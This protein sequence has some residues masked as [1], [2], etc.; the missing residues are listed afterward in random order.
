[1]TEKQRSTSHLN[2]FFRKEYRTMVRYVKARIDDAAERDGED[3]VQDVMASIITAGDVTVPINNLAAYLYEALRNRVVDMLRRRKKH[4]SLDAPLA[5][6]GE[7]AATLMDVIADTKH[8]TGSLAEK[9]QQKKLLME[10]M[11]EL[12]D[13]Q[14]A[15]IIAT[16]LDD[17]NF[18]ELAETWDVP[19]GT[20]LARKS[21]AV[22]KIRNKMLALDKVSQLS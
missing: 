3:I 7:E 21:R 18:S 15:V 6:E 1:M 13:D 11:D 17:R 22:E 9:N 19:I 4:L 20:L 16:E 8:D 2:D 10:A 5:F 14:R 12:P